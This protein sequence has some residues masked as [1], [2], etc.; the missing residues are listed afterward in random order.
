M[1]RFTRCHQGGGPPPGSVEPVAPAADRVEHYGSPMPSARRG[2]VTI[3]ERRSSIAHGRPCLCSRRSRSSPRT[4]A[5]GTTSQNVLSRRTHC[6]S[7]RS[8]SSRAMVPSAMRRLGAAFQPQHRTDR[9]F[10]PPSTSLLSST[11]HGANAAPPVTSAAGMVAPVTAARRSR[12]RPPP[13]LTWCFNW[14]SPQPPATS[15]LRA[16]VDDG[17][18]SGRAPLWHAAGA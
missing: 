4:T 13:T 18:E 5:G 14:A 2:A 8:P 6:S 1:L 3:I 7:S 16:A 17:S 10:V 9:P 15:A 11:A 12:P